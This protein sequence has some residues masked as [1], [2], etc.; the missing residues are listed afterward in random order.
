MGNGTMQRVLVIDDQLPVAKAITVALEAEGFEAAFANSGGAGLRKFESSSFD[1]V[2]VDIYMPG[3]D[4]AN[5]I[6][7]LRER[8]PRLPII[9][10]SG[11]RLNE[12]KRTVLDVLTMARGFSD[13]ICLQKPIRPAAL[14]EAIH[15]A[16]SIVT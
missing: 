14:V 10:M 5:I 16:M 4:G 6:R 15:K 2:I 12:T 7:A 8:N 11:V 9:A 13:V 3:M 1:V